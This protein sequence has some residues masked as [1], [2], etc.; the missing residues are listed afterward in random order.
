MHRRKKGDHANFRSSVV[1]DAEQERFWLDL[2]QWIFGPKMNDQAHE[3]K[4]K[5]ALPSHLLNGNHA[6]SAQHSSPLRRT[7]VN[8]REREKLTASIIASNSRRQAIDL[9]TSDGTPDG[10]SHAID[11]TPGGYEE[12]V[13]VN[14]APRDPRDEPSRAPPSAASRPAS[15]YTQNPPIDFDG[16]SWP[17]ECRGWSPIHLLPY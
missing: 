5:T 14:V 3:S 15:P 2:P 16:L 17:S 10:Q 4:P 9:E 12:D 11:L 6:H 13:E 7:S 8:A 1:R